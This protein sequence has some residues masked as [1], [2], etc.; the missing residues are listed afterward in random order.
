MRAVLWAAV[1]LS[2]LHFIAEAQQFPGFTRLLALEPDSA[3]KALIIDRYLKQHPAPIVEGV[4]VNFVYRGSARAAAV[5]GDLNGWNPRDAPMKRIVGTDLFVRRETLPDDARVEYKISA[6]SAWILDPLNP[7]KAAGGFG[8]NSEL[9]MPGYTPFASDTT[10]RNPGRTVDTLWLR[11]EALQ[12]TYP[13][14]ILTPLTGTRGKQLPAL[15]V[16]DGGEYLTLA[17]MDAAINRL[18]ASQAIRPVLGVFVDPRT[19]PADRSSNK[20]MTDYAANDSYLYFLEK[21]LTPLLERRYGISPDPHDR[22]ILGASMGGLIATYAVL[23][24]P[25]FIANC[26]AQSPAYWQADTAVIKFLRRTGHC[27][28]D[29]YIQ[30]GTIHDTR[31]EAQLVERLLRERG[32]RT[33]YE[34]YHEGHNWGNWRTKVEPILRHFFPPR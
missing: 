17:R 22:L 19:D 13:V 27:V 4:I 31:M 25:G 3:K 26:A 18:I 9:L 11:S 21:E 24:R 34:E 12:R 8:E 15:Y 29:F 7:R 23:R 6:D 1:L 32:A 14:Y 10:S 33:T 28:G 16:T 2:G 20:R 30:T 5:P